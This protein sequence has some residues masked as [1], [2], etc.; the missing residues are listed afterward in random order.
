MTDAP[1]AGPAA[2]PPQ[3]PPPAKVNSFERLLGVI[4]SP[5][6]TFRSI[7]QRPDWV[8]PLIVMVIISVGTIA[9]F[10]PRIDWDPLRDQLADQMSTQGRDVSDSDLQQMIS[11]SKIVMYI[12]SVVGIP[13]A[14]LVIALVFLLAFKMFGGEGDF[15]QYFSVVIYSFVPQMISSILAVIILLIK[16]TVRLDAIQTLVMSNL[17]FLADPTEQ[18]VQFALLSS[19]DLF[20]FW[21]LAL[22]VIGFGLVSKLSK[23]Q[24]IGIVIAVWLIYVIGKV[25]LSAAGAAMRSG[26]AS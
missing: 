10:A 1:L 15:G 20:T 18:A 23:G 6:E 8:V 4:F 19:I 2:P 24:V 3:T 25:G 22:L 9:L 13:I 26:A 11:V 5:G 17:G 14:T 21:T 12:Q 7:A 16:G